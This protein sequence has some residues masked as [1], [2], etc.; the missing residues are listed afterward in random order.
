M[1]RGWG[2]VLGSGHP[3]GVHGD[4]MGARTHGGDRGRRHAVGRSRAVRVCEWGRGQ[5]MG[6]GWGEWV[7]QARAR[8]WEWRRVRERCDD[9]YIVIAADRG[10]RR[11]GV[12]VRARARTRSR[13]GDGI[14]VVVAVFVVDEGVGPW[15]RPV[16][17]P[18]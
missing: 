4:P 6:M 16:G 8:E 15:G 2:W 9:V 12:E 5:G 7:V 17:A 13:Q 10:W 18:G 14:A 11:V 3:K 1:G